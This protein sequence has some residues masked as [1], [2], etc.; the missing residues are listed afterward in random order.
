MQYFTAHRRLQSIYSLHLVMM[1]RHIR[2]RCSLNVRVHQMS[3]GSVCILGAMAGSLPPSCSLRK[4]D[5]KDFYLQP[6]RFSI[7]T[8]ATPK[9][10]GRASGGKS[11]GD[12]YCLC[13]MW[14]PVDKIILDLEIK[15]KVT[16]YNISNR[17]IRWLISTSITVIIKHYLR[18][19][20]PFSKHQHFKLMTL[21]M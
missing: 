2:V 12:I 5:S 13:A 7:K 16:R 9:R 8:R 15:V 21:T 18:Q 1:V 20:S 3:H 11:A 14:W 6:S 19:L 4:W 10:R 17:A